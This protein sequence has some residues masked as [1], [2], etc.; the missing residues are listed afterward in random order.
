ELNKNIST[1]ILEINEQ[2]IDELQSNMIKGYSNIGTIILPSNFQGFCDDLKIFNHTKVNCIEIGK[3]DDLLGLNK[4]TP[5][6][7]NNLL[8]LFTLFLDYPITD[9][10]LLNDFSIFSINEHI[11]KKQL[12][13]IDFYYQYG[14]YY[15][16]TN[17][18]KQL[19]GEINYFSNNDLWIK[20]RT[21]IKEEQLQ[22]TNWNEIENISYFDLYQYLQDRKELNLLEN[23]SNKI[24]IY[25]NNNWY[26][27]ISDNPFEL[28]SQI[29]GFKNYYCSSEAQAIMLYA[30]CWGHFW[31][32][33]LHEGKIPPNQIVNKKFLQNSN[34]LN[35][36]IRGS[37]FQ[38][39]ELGISKAKSPSFDMVVW[40]GVEY[41][42]VEF[43]EQLKSF[44]L[45]D[46]DG[47][48]YSN[49]IG[50]IITSNGF[51]STTTMKDH[52]ISFTDGNNWTNNTFSPPLKSNVA[53][54]VKIPKNSSGVGYVSG[55]P[56][57]SYKLP[58]GFNPYN[59]EGQ[60]I[61]NRN[62]RFSID[63]IYK[64]DITF[65]FEVTLLS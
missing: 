56:L 29:K 59:I 19:N 39:M 36:E 54:K 8:N 63:N 10:E 55:F 30:N 48:D 27:N 31:N 50:K 11:Y 4:I 32:Q 33:W 65:I 16:N 51:I 47:Y 6:K 34:S 52:A 17:K 42:E 35:Y 28:D 18:Y 41:M 5:D 24:G 58:S 53:F 14:N 45:K 49:C 1:K 37:D 23:W 44:I 3:N 61:I 9:D 25:F 7:N 62:S 60:Y 43:Y 26:S 64:E 46:D 21:N 38:Y 15:F 57:T 12:N 2:H 20:I 13:G 22:I 40:H